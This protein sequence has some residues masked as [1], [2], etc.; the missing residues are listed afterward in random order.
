[1]KMKMKMKV[2]VKMKKWNKNTYNGIYLVL[3]KKINVDVRGYKLK[4]VQR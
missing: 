3:N 1:M 4:F 2:K